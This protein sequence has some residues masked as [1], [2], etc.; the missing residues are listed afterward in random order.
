METP[1]RFAASC[2]I[3]SV[4][5]FLTAKYESAVE[6]H[7]QF[8]SVYSEDVMSVQ[9]VRCWQTVFIEGRENVHDDE[10]SG[11]PAT[12]CQAEAITAVREVIDSDKRLTLDEIMTLLPPNIEI[13][14]SSLHNILVEVAVKKRITLH[15]SQLAAKR[16]GVSMESRTIAC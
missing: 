1:F 7:C 4:I 13:S 3:Q 15:I 5:R 6:I 11:R 8:C 14:R 9:M 12:S 10:R 16:S 2:E